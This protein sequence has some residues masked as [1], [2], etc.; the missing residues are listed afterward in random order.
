MYYVA[1]LCR[2]VSQSV[3]SCLEIYLF[4]RCIE[5][6]SPPGSV[7]NDSD[8]IPLNRRRTNLVGGEISGDG[9]V[10]KPAVIKSFEAEASDNPRTTKTTYR[11][12]NSREDCILESDYYQPT[13]QIGCQ[14][15]P[16]LADISGADSLSQT[17]DG[18]LEEGLL[19]GNGTSGVDESQ[20]IFSAINPKYDEPVVEFIEEETGIHLQLPYPVLLPSFE[21]SAVNMILLTQQ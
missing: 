18:V 6:N 11:N 17:I 12:T 21:V 15:T 7:S 10:S 19:D 4:F 14:E 9:A 20:L 5:D 13:V 16:G 1:I 3:V 2:R 8:E